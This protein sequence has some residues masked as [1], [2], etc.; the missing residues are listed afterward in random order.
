MNQRPKTIKLRPKTIKLYEENIGE[1]LLELWTWQRFLGYD[2]K[3]TDKK[4]DRN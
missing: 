1:K 2:T 4:L 3:N